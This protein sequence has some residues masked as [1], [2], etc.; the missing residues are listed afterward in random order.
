MD[1]DVPRLAMTGALKLVGRTVM[2]KIIGFAANVVVARILLPRQFGILA[3]GFTIYTFISFLGSI[4]LGANLVRRAPEPTARE[5]SIVMGVQLAWAGA[6]LVV[7][8]SLI[9]VLGQTMLVAAIM[10]AALPFNALRVPNGI[11]LERQLSYGVP[12]AVDIVSSFVQ[13]AASVVLVVLGAGVFGVAI[14]APLGALVGT[15][16]MWRWGPLGPVRP[17]VSLSGSW[18]MIS[19]GTWFA[20]ADFISLIRDQGLN[21]TVQL[22]GGLASLG[23][24][25]V[26]GR[27]LIIPG[28]VIG[29]LW[30]VSFPAMSRLRD[31][32]QD[33]NRA[34]ARSVG[35]TALGLGLPLAMVGGPATLVVQVLFG[36]HWGGVAS[37]LPGVCVGYLINAPISVGA[38]GRLY[39]SGQA[40]TV[41]ASV[42]AHSVVGLAVTAFAFPSL[43]LA[44]IGLALMMGSVVDP[45]VFLRALDGPVLPVLRAQAAPT[46]AAVAAGV[47]GWLVSRVL[48]SNLLSLVAAEA[49]VTA[50]YL[51][52][53]GL[54]GRHSLADGILVARIQLRRTS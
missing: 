47:A 18:A 40:R 21:V 9:P 39:A 20:M 6:G 36:S 8:C 19:E 53:L 10:L 3:L 41:A 46:V 43:H 33:V 50:C 49:S 22:A 27:I 52:V 45:V 37:I 48:P 1:L 28:F 29:T 34:F 12:A 30:Q 13:S 14:S 15:V 16:L 4:G 31:Q 11:V 23:A 51:C 54:I 7:L 26:A 42:A 44:A 25:A 17:L 32:G 38:A 5:L 35:L 24:W 2:S